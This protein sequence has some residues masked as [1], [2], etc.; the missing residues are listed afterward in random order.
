MVGKDIV[1][2]CQLLVFGRPL[3]V[4]AVDP[5]L[6]HPVSEDSSA[7]ANAVVVP[8]LTP[9]QEWFSVEFIFVIPGIY[10]HVTSP[11]IERRC[12]RFGISGFANEHP[13]SIAVP[14]QEGWGGDFSKLSRFER[15][16]FPR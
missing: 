11:R 13:G 5:F 15:K 4:C 10:P 9:V 12:R 16:A 2:L 8:G 3:L 6:S 14:C 1:L 7:S